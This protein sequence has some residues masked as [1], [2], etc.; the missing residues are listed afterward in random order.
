MGSFAPWSWLWAGV[1]LAPHA[2]VL[3]LEFALARL[4]RAETHSRPATHRG[5]LAPWCAEVAWGWRAFA[6]WQAWRRDS[7][8]DASAGIAG[9]RGV[10]LVHGLGCNRG[11]WTLW[12]KQCRAQ[13]I[14]CRAPSFSPS[15][16]RI[17]DW[18]ADIDRAVAEVQAATGVPPWLVGHSMGGLA[19]RAWAATP[20]SAGRYAGVVSIATPHHGTWLAR[21]GVTLN[22]RQMRPGSAWLQGLAAR[23]LALAG[24]GASPAWICYESDADNVVLPFGVGLKPG[25]AHRV[26]RGVAHVQLA[27]Q[28]GVID[29]VLAEVTAR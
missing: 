19:I 12:L 21:F 2:P 7:V 28:R 10:V 27:M 3:A 20:A 22:A 15:F 14:V 4:L 8:P 6:W 13:R 23:E 29:E 24:C 25:A 11:F 1:W 16:G 17:D 9:Q 26:V 18:C 5:G